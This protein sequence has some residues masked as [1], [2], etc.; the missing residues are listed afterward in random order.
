MELPLVATGVGGVRE[1]VG[2]CGSIVP[3]KNP[4]ALAQAMLRTM[5]SSEQDRRA[6]ARAAR[7]RILHDFSLDARTDEWEALYRSMTT[8]G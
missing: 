7:Q 1:L 2:E 4:E 5:K 6:L 8:A 3:P